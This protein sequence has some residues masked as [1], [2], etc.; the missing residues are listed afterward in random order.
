MDD[1][2]GRIVRMLKAEGVYENTPILFV[3]DNG[4]SGEMGVFGTHFEGGMYD[5][6]AGKFENGKFIPGGEKETDAWAVKDRL[7]GRLSK[8][9]L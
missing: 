3:S 8:R 6:T 9:Q 7:G 1:N 2:I 4:C 5:Y